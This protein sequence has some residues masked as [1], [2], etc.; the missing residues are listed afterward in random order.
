LPDGQE[1]QTLSGRVERVVYHDER[2]R[3][4]VLRLLVP[5]HDA[6][7]TA[8]GRARSIDAG[9]DVTL[10]GQWDEHPQHGRQFQFGQVHVEVPT[11]TAGIERRLR[12][13]PGVKDVM[14]ARIV[15]RFG[16]DTLEILDKQPRRLLEV[17]GI[18]ARTLERIL[19]HHR[20]QVGP[21]AE[22]ESTLLELDLPAYLAVAIHERYGEAAMRMVRE[23]PYRL[24]R[25]VRGIGFA[26]AD[27]IARALGIDP[28]SPDRIEAGLVFVLEQAEQDGHCALPIAE[29]VAKTATALEVTE[30][31]VRDAGEH[32]VFI[33]DLVLEHG[34]DGTALCFPRKF[35]EAERSIARALSELASATHE[36]WDVGPLPDHLSA[37]Q[38]DA[39]NAVAAHGVVV[40][41]GGPGTGKST[42]V[43]EIIAVARANGAEL[44]LA[45]PTGRAAKRLEQATNVEA[46]TVHRLLE[47]QPESGHFGHGPHDPLAPGLVVVDESSMLDTTLAEA[48]LRALTPEHRLLLVGDADQLPSVGAGNVLRDVMLAAEHS[49]TPLCLV[50]LT[51]VFR[52]A[53]GSSIIANAHLI[54]AGKPLAPD[55]AGARGEFFVVP[56]R[57]PDHAHDLIVRMATERIPAAYELNARTEIQVLCPMHKGRGGTEALNRTLQDFHTQGNAELVLRTQA[58]TGRRFRVGDRV[59][60]TRNDYDKGV[61]NGDVGVVV[62][63]DAELNTL[64]AEMD[65]TRINYT[66]KDMQALQLAYAISIHKSQ[67]S[68]FRAVLVSILPEHHVMLQRNLLYTA[69]TRAQS[70]CVV[71][72]EPQSIRRAIQ[73]VEAGRRHTALGRR[74]IE[75]MTESLVSISPGLIDP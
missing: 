69:I 7:V 71:V 26:T 48:L 32:M 1:A 44:Q 30:D 18:G 31:Q 33:G 64:V 34:N 3:Y 52:Q 49:D 60:Q 42:V 13:Y 55:P 75:S 63:L 21:L 10:L 68:E 9:A 54:L 39:V 29:L 38:R 73:R 70:L 16:G 58:V 40:L 53:E 22:L 6:L 2:S 41:T 8:V 74:L 12:R 72:G 36:Q 56:A 66:S 47:F 35:V 23:S 65:G 46:K 15:A 59:M 17:E 45:A 25:D 43:R 28:N 51:E 67:G 61:F 4:T 20:E 37:G 27:R 24:A 50:R 57:N 5:G 14:A 62:A 11:T 19:T